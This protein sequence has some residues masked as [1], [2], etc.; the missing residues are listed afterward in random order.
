MS[1]RYAI[2]HKETGIVIGDSDDNT[3]AWDAADKVASEQRIA[4]YEA[5]YIAVPYDSDEQEV[6]IL[7]GIVTL[8]DK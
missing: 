5:W 6:R 2:M 8:V 1:L 4:D 3:Q 7:G